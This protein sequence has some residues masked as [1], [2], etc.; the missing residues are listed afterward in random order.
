MTRRSTNYN[1]NFDLT[2]SDSDFDM[3]YMNNNNDY[4]NNEYT[5]NEY[6]DNEYNNNEYFNN[7]YN[8]SPSQYYNDHDID[9]RIDDIETFMDTENS[10]I[11]QVE[12]NILDETL[13]ELLDAHYDFSSSDYYFED[14]ES[15]NTDDI[16]ELISDIGTFQTRI[17][18]EYN[19]WHDDII[20]LN[21][22]NTISN[23]NTNSN[24]NADETIVEI[25]QRV[26]TIRFPE[27]T[28]S[29]DDE[30]VNHC[31]NNT[32]INMLHKRLYNRRENSGN[33]ECFICF[34]D[35]TKKSLV[36][37][38]KCSHIFHKSC[39]KPWFKK[40]RRCPLCRQDAIHN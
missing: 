38:L 8:N 21:N 36:I 22:T 31:L 13:I 20:D 7:D 35:F 19:S 32:E 11:L 4:K 17:T 33:I 2:S 40:D 10:D 5:N 30:P 26:R 37:E 1:K 24:T 12:D 16:D 14:T 6:N 34:T 9:D 18:E 39:I 23:N 29:Y 25:N 27:G 15:F 3:P 28:V